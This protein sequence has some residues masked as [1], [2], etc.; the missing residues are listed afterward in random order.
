MD[1]PRYVLPTDLYR[2]ADFASIAVA[3]GGE[4]ADPD[5][6]LESLHDLDVACPFKATD[7]SVALRIVWDC[8]SAKRLDYVGLPIHNIVPGHVVRWQMHASNVWTAPT[9]NAAMTMGA[10]LP[11]GHSR[12]PWVDLT[13]VDGYDVAGFRWWSLLVPI[14]TL[15]VQLGEV[16][17]G[18]VLSDLP[19]GIEQGATLAEAHPVLQ[20]LKTSAGYETRYRLPFR[21]RR[22]AGRCVDVDSLTVLRQL[23]GATGG[24]DPFVFI[25][26]P[27][28]ETDGGWLAQFGEQTAAELTWTETSPDYTPVDIEILEVPRG[29]PL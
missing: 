12:A 26:D 3:S 20:A 7:G 16:V 28:D 9:L 19:T 4:S 21:N 6:Q 27:A 10:L 13:Q 11:S 22:L 1:L 23:H 24:C 8:G 14:N 17:L 25:L 18:R 5:Y 15:P 29:L 2:Y